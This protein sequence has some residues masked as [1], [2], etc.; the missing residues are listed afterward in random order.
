MYVQHCF[1]VSFDFTL[2]QKLMVYLIHF[3]H[4]TSLRVVR[5][6]LKIK[7]AT[8]PAFKAKC[9]QFS[10]SKASITALDYFRSHSEH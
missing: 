10:H 8:F 1:E 9:S 7:L 2:S 3:L 5:S 4:Q 6:Q